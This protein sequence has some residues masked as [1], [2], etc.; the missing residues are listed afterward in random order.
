MLLLT[1]TARGFPE[2]SSSR[3]TFSAGRAWL[4][5]RLWVASELAG[6][7]L[8]FAETENQFLSTFDSLSFRTHNKSTIKKSTSTTD[9]DSNHE[10]GG[11]AKASGFRKLEWW[12]SGK[13]LRLS[14]SIHCSLEHTESLLSSHFEFLPDKAQE[15]LHCQ[16]QVQ[17]PILSRLPRLPHF[18]LPGRFGQSLNLLK[19]DSM[20]CRGTHVR[21]GEGQRSAWQRISSL[22]QASFVFDFFYWIPRKIL[23]WAIL[24]K[25]KAHILGCFLVT[26]FMTIEQSSASGRSPVREAHV[27]FDV[28]VCFT[29]KH[30]TYDFT[31][32]KTNKKK[33]RPNSVPNRNLTLFL[34]SQP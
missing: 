21:K 30:N 25:K 23:G 19:R 14:A 18:A 13:N 33:T 16:I 20:A 12:S 28:G 2:H 15:W 9:Q 6:T 10:V 29:H 27:L 1:T 31:I 7:F 5:A 8:P 24:E 11:C 4:E 32:F 17:I 22:P 26:D 3:A 34:L